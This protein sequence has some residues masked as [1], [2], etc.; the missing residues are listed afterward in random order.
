MLDAADL[1]AFL[2]NNQVD[3][4]VITTDKES[5]Q[6]VTEVLT[7]SGIRGIWNF[8][9][10]ELDVPEDMVVENVHLSD[11]LHMLTYYLNQN[12]LKNKE[13]LSS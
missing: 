12:S 3:I 10:A 1:P 11:S 5:A 9:A 2:E 13:Q 4:A 8:T 7:G 6:S